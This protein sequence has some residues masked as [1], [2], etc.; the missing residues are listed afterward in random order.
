MWC[1]NPASAKTLYNAAWGSLLLKVQIPAKAKRRLC[2]LSYRVKWVRVR[3]WEDVTSIFAI[4]KWA[5]VMIKGIFYLLK[6]QAQWTGQSCFYYL[7]SILLCF[8]V[9]RDLQSP[10]KTVSLFVFVTHW[11]SPMC[12]RAC[13]LDWNGWRASRW[14]LLSLGKL[15]FCSNMV[16]WLSAL[17]KCLY[18]SR[19][20]DHHYKL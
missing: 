16:L 1:Y 18:Q 2:A 20:P 6:K 13:I 7:K 17:T 3:L 9:A 11:Q 14:T 4:S 15:C 12:M 8:W 5:S 10:S 19:A